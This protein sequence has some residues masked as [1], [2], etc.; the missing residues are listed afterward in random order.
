MVF[1]NPFNYYRRLSI[2]LQRL[3]CRDFIKFAYRIIMIG[4]Q[5]NSSHRSDVFTQGFIYNFVTSC[6]RFLCNILRVI[7]L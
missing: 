4:S 1:G 5:F 3:R 2:I 6:I 7:T